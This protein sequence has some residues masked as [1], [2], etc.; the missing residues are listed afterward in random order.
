MGKA[1]GQLL[2]IRCGKSLPK[3]LQEIMAR[4][5]SIYVEGTEGVKLFPTLVNISQ[6]LLM[7]LMHTYNQTNS[8][9]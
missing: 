1:L 6:F 4:L 7:L 9:S 8:E 2:V 3:Q 5:H